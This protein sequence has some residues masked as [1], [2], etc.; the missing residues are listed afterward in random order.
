[1]PGTNLTGVLL[2]EL[3]VLDLC[4]GDADAVT[5]LFADLGA[6]VLKVEP[7]GGNAS[8]SQLPSV[9]G[10]SVPFAL[11]NANK[12]GCMLDPDDPRDR[13]RFYELVAGA[14]IVVDSGN[15]GRSAAFGTSCA[16]LSAQLSTS[17]RDVGHRLRRRRAT[18]V[19]VRHRPGVLC[20]VH[21]A[22][23]IRADDRTS[24]AAAQRPCLGHRRCAG[25]MG[26]AC[27]VLSTD[28]ITA[29]AI[30]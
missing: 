11:N 13:D 19:V 1:M 7:P 5:R 20:A 10:T 4:D 2:A 21:V 23:A 16:E 28:C 25:G 24:G 12:R 6:D 9:A 3:R 14:D 18:S 29:Q 15:P 30:T 8:R 27:R 26:G 22:V 17:G